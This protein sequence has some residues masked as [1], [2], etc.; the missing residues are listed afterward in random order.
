MSRMLQW[1]VAMLQAI[2]HIKDMLTRL[3]KVHSCFFLSFLSFHLADVSHCFL[4]A[5][6]NRLLQYLSRSRPRRLPSPLCLCSLPYGP[7]C[8]SYGYFIA[9][10]CQVSRGFWFII[11]GNGQGKSIWGGGV[12]WGLGQGWAE[13]HRGSVVTNK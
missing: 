12:R 4:M 7:L 6:D 2:V 8:K 1:L 10:H 3:T 13:E 11:Q 5:C 9:L